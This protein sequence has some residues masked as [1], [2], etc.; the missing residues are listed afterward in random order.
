MP[1][2]ALTVSQYNTYIK[3]IFDAEE[4]LHNIKIVGEVFGVSISRGVIYFSLKD[5]SSSIN[6]VCF[7]NQLLSVITEGTKLVVT[8]SPNYYI[9]A[10]KLSFVVNKAEKF[11][12]GELYLQ[13]LLMKDKLE[14]EGLF[15][16]SKKK[17]IPK[18]IKSIGVITS[19][20]GAVIHDICSVC[21]RRDPSVNIAIFPVKVQGVGAE[22][23]IA[24]AIELLSNYDKIDVIIVARGGGSLEDLWAY[25][26]E[27]VAR[28]TF[29]CQ[30]P[31]I[32]A[33][34][35]ET[36]FT[37][38]DFVSDLRAPTPSAAA[39]LLTSEIGQKRGKFKEAINT[40]KSLLQRYA[41][42]TTNQF[43]LLA[44]NL[45]QINE[46]YIREKEFELGLIEKSL[47]N[48]DPASILKRGYAK[49]QQNGKVVDNATNV[50][51]S[52]KLEIILYNGKIIAQPEE[53]KNV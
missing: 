30:K 13:F 37:I 53:V 45:S 17:A 29:N 10:G 48:L 26:T 36:D 8:G 15:D 44:S 16:L 9:K 18:D 50:V 49:V 14:K 51:L 40:F 4:L 31:I 22:E 47:Q 43:N 5:E 23:E 41:C 3:Q 24:K 19:K 25:N 7:I 11:G 6:C 52:S 33:V 35:H 46:N 42:D 20:E 38:I 21:W 1:L 32:S 2:E 28:A 34:G 27:K 39:E 12:Q